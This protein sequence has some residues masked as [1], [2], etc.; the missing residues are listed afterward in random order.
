MMDADARGNRE[1][2][3]ATVDGQEAGR[4]INAIHVCTSTPSK[5]NM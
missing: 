2:L 3:A 5:P 1:T 4:A